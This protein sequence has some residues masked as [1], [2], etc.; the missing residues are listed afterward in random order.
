MDQVKMILQTYA[1]CGSIKGTARRLQVSKN[2]VRHYVR[3][4]RDAAI[5]L[6]QIQELEEIPLQETL[7]ATSSQQSTE[8]EAVFE[9]KVQDWLRELRRVGVTR[10]LL[11]EEYR[12]E[13]P[14]GYG[15]SQFCE[16]LKRHSFRH[17]LTI[18]LEHKGGEVMQVDFAGKKM[19]WVNPSSGEVHDCEILVAVLP[20]S[21]YTFAIALQSQ[22]VADFVHGLNQ[23]LL[24][25]GKLPKVILS[26]NLK[27]YVTRADRYDP[28][29]NELCVQ[30][31]AHYQFDLD[32]TRVA[33]PR[34][35]ASTE[36]AVRTV[37]T[38]IYAPL[39][40][41]VFYSSE[42]LNEAIRAQ[43]LLH[44]DKP[45]QKKAGSRKSAFEAYE[46]PF[47]QDLPTDLFEA[48][49]IVQAKV[50]RNYHVFLGEEKNY[51]SVPFQYAGQKATVAYNTKVVEVFIGPQRVA[52]H[53]RL[54]HYAQYRYQTKE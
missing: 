30:L 9:Q 32:A 34:D 39:R 18:A 2:T 47:M 5:D 54:P 48:R 15:Y 1:K 46:K 51:Y 7:Y 10:H 13:H 28:D 23:A 53:S 3:L 35:K 21:Q 17:D 20:H 49:K 27:S 29:F 19:S 25:F 38:R 6:H 8:R 24:F 43:V 31:A 50:Q 52:I 22:K 45:Y 40:N 4:A 16:L 14:D 26:D 33:K 11:W 44:N 37:Y 12:A 36:N 42:Q 41:E